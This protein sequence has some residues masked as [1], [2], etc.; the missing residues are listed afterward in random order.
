[1]STVSGPTVI[2]GVALTEEELAM[3]KDYRAV[4]L[5]LARLKATDDFAKWL[6]SLSTI[7][8]SLGAAL[9]NSSAFKLAGTGKTLLGAA[10]ALTGISFALATVALL[11]DVGSAN[12]NAPAEMVAKVVRNLS[13]K[14]WLLGFAVG[15]LGLALVLAGLAPRSSREAPQR[16]GIS[17]VLNG[18]SLDVAY[19]AP[20]MADT[21]ELRV[22]GNGPSNTTVLLAK[23]SRLADTANQ[24]KLEILKITIP[25]DVNKVTMSASTGT[26]AEMPVQIQ[27]R[28]AASTPVQHPSKKMK[29]RSRAAKTT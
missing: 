6:F 20:A 5:P 10:V 14:R 27:V 4:Y 2:H 11:I 15:C 13:I 22:E 24:A 7:I 29:S 17:Y 28:P 18:A 12:P 23:T 1:M 9:S 21:A 8:G 19:V 25:P 3:F 16:N 26:K